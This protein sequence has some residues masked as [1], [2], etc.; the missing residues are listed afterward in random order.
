MAIDLD[1]EQEEKPKLR[2]QLKYQGFNIS[3][4]CLCV[5]VEPW[6]RIRAPSMAP[7][8]SNTTKAQSIAPV[9]S[10]SSMETSYRERTPL[11]LPDPDR[12][13]SE[14]PAPS[15]P[16]RV[17]PPVPLFNDTM[18]QEIE[19]SDDDDGL[20]EFSQVLNYA[21]EHRAGLVDDDDE[22]D[23][24]VFFGDADEAREF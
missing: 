9:N 15:L 1:I 4:N 14:T 21:G 20:M 5:V 7:I 8:F 10:A 16:R 17:L 6:P 13:R 19:D 12:G 22:I 3:G 2:L 11:F 23:G 24:A 18:D